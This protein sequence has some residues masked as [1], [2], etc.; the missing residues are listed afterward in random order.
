[1]DRR[2]GVILSAGLGLAVLAGCSGS[3]EPVG[4][5]LPTAAP[6]SVAPTTPLAAEVTDAVETYEAF[7]KAANRAREKPVVQGK[8][9]PRGAEFEDWSYD[10]ARSDTAVFVHAL[11][12]SNA[13]YRGTP[14]VS[15]VSVVRSDLEAAPYPKVELT[16]CQV[17]EGPYVPYD[18]STGEKLE[19]VGEVDPEDPFLSEIVVVAVNGQWGVQSVRL[20]QGL[21]CQP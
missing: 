19:L 11:A 9:W 21:P 12:E 7:Q 13:E 3:Q 20:R 5:P 15:H 16:D 6:P 2:T 17:P 8:R 14:P 10:P 1:M 4:E 18:R